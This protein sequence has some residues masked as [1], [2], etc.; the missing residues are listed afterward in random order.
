MDSVVDC[1]ADYSANLAR[2]EI[3]IDQEL[4]MSW[5][6]SH[7]EIPGLSFRKAMLPRSVTSIRIPRFSSAPRADLI[8]CISKDE[9]RRMQRVWRRCDHSS[10]RNRTRHQNLRP[11]RETAF[12]G[13]TTR[14]P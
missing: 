5:S 6:A 2:E 9:Q 10:P 4:V 8:D 7:E 13:N 1:D 3:M 11:T 12:D 14:R